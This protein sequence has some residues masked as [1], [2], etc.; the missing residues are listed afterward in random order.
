MKEITA[1]SKRLSG[2]CLFE[3]TQMYNLELEVVDEDSHLAAQEALS[4]AAQLCL[5]VVANPCTRVVV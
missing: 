2:L 5:V 3:N 4:R 1:H